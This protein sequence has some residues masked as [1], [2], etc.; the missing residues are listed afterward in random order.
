MLDDKKLWHD[1]IGGVSVDLAIAAA[2][3]GIAWAGVSSLAGTAAVGPILAVIIVSSAIAS[4][5]YNFIDTK[6]LTKKLATSL[7]IAESNAK[8][9]LQKI[10]NNL[11]DASNMYEENPIKFMHNLFAI[12]YLKND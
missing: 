12:P 8:N 6:T 4:L 5:A 2:S 7:R 11:R 3:S 9:N 1:F 10:H